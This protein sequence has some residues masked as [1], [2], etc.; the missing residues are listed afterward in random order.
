MAF[1][2]FD[3][4]IKSAPGSGDSCTAAQSNNYWQKVSPERILTD[5]GWTCN[6]WWKKSEWCAKCRCSNKPLSNF[7]LR[8]FFHN[9]DSRSLFHRIRSIPDF[10][11]FELLDQFLGGK[12]REAEK[13]LGAVPISFC[14]LVNVLTEQN[15]IHTIS[16][17]FWQRKCQNIRQKLLV[18]DTVG[19]KRTLMYLQKDLGL[20]GPPLTFP[21][22]SPLLKRFRLQEYCQ[23]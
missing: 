9:F 10:R 5:H 3:K 20:S 16:K 12:Q 23:D 18:S 2:S 15:T 1:L 7:D 14:L 21:P 8:S 17:D 4:R 19:R 6:G 11:D 22:K 13:S